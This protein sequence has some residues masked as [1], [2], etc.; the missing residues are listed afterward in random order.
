[1]DVVSLHGVTLVV[2]EVPRLVTHLIRQVHARSVVVGHVHV[3]LVHL[4]LLVTVL[5]IVLV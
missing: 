2:V 5:L 4:H 3:V 1:M